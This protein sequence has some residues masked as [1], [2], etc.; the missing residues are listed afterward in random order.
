VAHTFIVFHGFNVVVALDGSQ[1]QTME[2]FT[3]SQ[4][5]RVSPAELG[6]FLLENNLKA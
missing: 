4:T 3:I 6:V 5:L 1:T 2:D